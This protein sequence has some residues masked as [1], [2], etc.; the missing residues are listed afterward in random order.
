[1]SAS[2]ENFRQLAENIQDI[3][4]IL[5]VKDS[6]FIYVSPMYDLSGD[7]R[8][9]SSWCAR[10]IEKRFD[11]IQLPIQIAQLLNWMPIEGN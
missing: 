5:A 7:R 11:P 10:L 9:L 2:E 6:P 3:F 4:W 1:M 8:A